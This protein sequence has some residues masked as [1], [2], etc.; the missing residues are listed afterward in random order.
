[1]AD[2]DSLLPSAEEIRKKSA[3]MEGRQASEYVRKRAAAEAEKKE[4]L[5]QFWMKNFLKDY[6]RRL[7]NS[8]WITGPPGPRSSRP[9]KN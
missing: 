2:L 6:L 5:K 9:S 8:K 4:L 3:E 7:E 1:M